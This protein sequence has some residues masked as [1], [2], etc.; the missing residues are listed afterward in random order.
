MREGPDQWA[1]ALEHEERHEK[2][3]MSEV[4]AFEI[5]VFSGPGNSPPA[6]GA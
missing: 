6:P 4:G 2:T 3:V 1:G 5:E